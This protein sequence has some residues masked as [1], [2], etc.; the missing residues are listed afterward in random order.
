M[1]NPPECATKQIPCESQQEI[2]GARESTVFCRLNAE[3]GFGTYLKRDSYGA[4]GG[5]QD[6]VPPSATDDLSP[7]SQELEEKTP[8][9]ITS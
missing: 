1:G 4:D 7:H 5:M 9:T 6:N 3:M 2:S 8:R